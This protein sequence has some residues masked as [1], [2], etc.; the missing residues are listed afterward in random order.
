MGCGFSMMMT[1]MMRR[2]KLREVAIV[3]TGGEKGGGRGDRIWD[4]GSGGRLAR[5]EEKEP[6]VLICQTVE[7]RSSSNLSRF[8]AQRRRPSCND[9]ISKVLLGFFFSEAESKNG[10]PRD[11]TCTYL[12]DLNL[13]ENH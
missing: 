6:S 2:G 10:R 8:F 1:P 9:A 3:R 4:P 5:T 11:N 7:A 13:V 12:Y